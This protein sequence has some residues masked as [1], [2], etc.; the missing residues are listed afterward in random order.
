LEAEHDELRN[1][2][3][4]PPILAPFLEEIGM[5]HEEF[6]ASVR[7]WKTLDRFRQKR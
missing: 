3:G 4:E 5:S 7:D 6:L 1:R 2:P